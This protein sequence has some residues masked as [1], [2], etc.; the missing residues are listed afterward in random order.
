MSACV[1]VRRRT[2]VNVYFSFISVFREVVISFCSVMTLVAGGSWNKWFLCN[3]K[4]SIPTSKTDAIQSIHYQS[5][6]DAIRVSQQPLNVYQGQLRPIKPIRHH[7]VGRHSD[8]GR[9]LNEASLK[10]SGKWSCGHWAVSQAQRPSDSH[11]EVPSSSD[12]YFFHLIY[13]SASR[14]LPSHL[15]TESCPVC[16]HTFGIML[17]AQA[18]CAAKG[19]ISVHCRRS[20]NQSSLCFCHR[21]LPFPPST[22]SLPQRPLTVCLQGREL[23]ASQLI[24]SCLA[25]V[26]PLSQ[27][28]LWLTLASQ[29]ASDTMRGEMQT[30]VPVLSTWVMMPAHL[31]RR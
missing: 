9:A 5:T 30:S 3:F 18:N 25:L 28:A 14:P 22:P 27:G 16:R 7:N 8:E 29:A 11:K 17:H 20:V 15:C 10:R 24:F 31:Q 13:S 26:A 21:A 12:L 6:A 23:Y 2:C 4:S 19:I 1:T